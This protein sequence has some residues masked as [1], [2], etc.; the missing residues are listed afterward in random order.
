MIKLTSAIIVG[1]VG[2]HFFEIVASAERRAVARQNHDFDTC[3]GRGVRNRSVDGRDHVQ[4]EAVPLTRPV[5]RQR[6]YAGAAI[7]L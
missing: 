3:I 7:K 4:R 2:G 6:E 5:Q 1:T